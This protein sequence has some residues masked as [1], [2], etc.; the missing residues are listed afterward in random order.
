MYRFTKSLGSFSWAMS[1]FGLHQ[2]GQLMGRGI[3][4]DAKRERYEDESASLDSVTR[5]LAGQ[6]G[7]TL[8]PIFKTGDDLLRVAMDQMSQ[9]L[10]GRWGNETED[11]DGF[12]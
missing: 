7:S 1:L 2:L 4:R 5:T 11:K 9:A 12:R 6:L 8:K 10:P 3:R